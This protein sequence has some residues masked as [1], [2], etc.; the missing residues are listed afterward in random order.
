MKKAYRPDVIEPKW[1]KKWEK[2]KLYK[3]ADKSDK[4]KFY[5][6]DFF[7]YPSGA[8]LHAGH[9]EGYTATDI[10]SRY[11]R[12][13]GYNV[14]HPMGWDA[15]G[16]PAENYAIKSGVHP[17]ETT[18]KAIA[19]YKRQVKMLGISYDWSREIDT[20]DP[21]Y[22]KWTQWF[23]LLM[24]ENGLAYR[25]K[26][27][28]NWCPTDQ[29]VLANE[30]VIKKDDKNVCERC[31]TEVEQRDLEQWFFRITDYTEELL[32]GL[33]RIDWPES[34]KQ[35]QRNWIGRQEGVNIFWPVVGSDLVL[36]T[37]TKFPET[38]FGAT[39]ISISPEHELVG[40]LTTPEH[41]NEVEKYCK[42]A[43]KK[44]NL[45]RTELE[46]DKTG[47]FTGSY[48]TNQ[49]TGEKVPVWVSDYVLA[50]YGT[51]VVFGCPAHD[52][53][54]FNFGKKYG[55]PI[56][57]VLVAKAGDDKVGPIE[58]EQDILEEGILVN[59][60]FLDGLAT[61]E[62]KQK[63]AE[64]LLEKGFGERHVFY[65][66]RDWLISRQRYWGPPI[67]IVDCPHC[68]HFEKEE[69]CCGGDC[70]CD[71]EE[72]EKHEHAHKHDHKHE[73]EE[74]GCCGG[75]CCGERKLQT[76]VVD[77][78]EYALIPV[79]LD[80]LP[81][82]LPNDVDFKPTGQ[83]PLVS[84]KTFHK[85]KCPNCGATKGVRRESDTLDTFVDSSWYFF[86]FIDP[87]NAK[88][89]A[90]QTKIDNFMPID[91]A[92]GG[93]E[94]T[95]LHL[96]YCRFFTK[97][98]FD[99][100]Y[101]EFDEPMAKLRHQGTV[102]GTD[103][104][105]MSK[106]WGNIINPD[107]VVAALG[108]DTMRTYE[109]FMGPIDATKAWSTGGVEGVRRFYNRVWDL[110]HQVIESKNKKSGSE[111]QKRINKLVKKVGSDI[112]ALKFNTAVAAMMEFVNF[113]QA[114]VKDVGLDAL[115]LFIQALAPF[116][117]H[118]AEELWQEMGEKYSV[119]V[120]PWPKYNE[121]LIQDEIVE[122]VVQVNGKLRGKIEVSTSEM[123]DKE[124]V[125]SR[126]L[127][128]EKV[129]EIVE[130]KTIKNFIYIEG[131]LVNIVI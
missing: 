70:G 24:F 123:G 39:F 35:G 99:V 43:K 128:A 71:H 111:V 8:G 53:R 17:N 98:L 108:A 130:N 56:K 116:G 97:V 91:F 19:N 115:K 119:T 41:K 13:K 36:A 14:L 45:Q 113:W 110:S 75:G 80:D 127:S 107:D 11:M 118:I 82:K 104:R 25:K 129:R 90:D 87:K 59:S 117:P 57:R 114:N 77:G 72:G 15:F 5:C 125:K 89:F 50:T 60:E 37:F 94:H 62:A 63:I 131:K 122:I 58:G 103:G 49:V 33:E 64:H 21:N 100:G 20:S 84:S 95:V 48:V 7:P 1:Q 76:T 34:T 12:T 18:Q 126:A 54:D 10:Y 3:T 28:V 68:A 61:A 69:E 85:V 92:F 46:K 40:K 124:L 23:F 66:L 30:Q 4:K 27:P 6:L 9:V 32:K 101:I 79:S 105:K 22:Y 73:K 86:R 31:E 29:T 93:A 44:T 109:M 47:V 26:A 121:E 2:D 42:D 102:L 96:L 55:L 74:G 83:S 112:E 106:R 88:T 51:G 67:P 78:V 16:L 38:I 120:A 52:K 65:N 81:V